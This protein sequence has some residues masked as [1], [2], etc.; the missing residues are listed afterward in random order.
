MNAFK[1]RL[2][3][4]QQELVAVYIPEHRRCSPMLRLWRAQKLDTLCGQFP[5]GLW[6]IVGPKYQR[7]KESDEDFVPW[8]SEQHELCFGARNPQLNPA[9]A[10]ERLVCPNLEP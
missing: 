7:L 3:G 8:G 9:L 10:S 1:H 6:H 4:R 5:I 2:F